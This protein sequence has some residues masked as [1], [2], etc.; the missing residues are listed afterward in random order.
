MRK[1]GILIIIL[2]FI[3]SGTLA[4]LSYHSADELAGP[5][6]EPVPENDREE[7][8]VAPIR[9]GLREEEPGQL[10]LSFYLD[11]DLEGGG[12]VALTPKRQVRDLSFVGEDGSL[13]FLF[14]PGW[15][16]AVE[17]GDWQELFY[18]WNHHREQT[19][20]LSVE[21]EEKPPPYIKLGVGSPA[22]TLNF[23]EGGRTGQIFE[24][25]PGGGLP[26]G[27]TFTPAASPEGFPPVGGRWKFF[28]SV[29]E[30]D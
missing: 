28:I 4:I 27:V 1:T 24:L 29:E 25:D 8:G 21:G 22:E 12:P 3:A 5:G 30:V 9:P 23:D 15:L 10:E 13:H 19:L 17:E 16:E 2:L 26:L 6:E 20:R 11:H 7:I 14:S 18:I